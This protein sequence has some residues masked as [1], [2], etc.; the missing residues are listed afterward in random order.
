MNPT[1]IMDLEGTT[2]SSSERNLLADPLVSG[3]IFFARN[4]IDR[5]QISHLIAEIRNIRPNLLL[6]VDQEGGRVQR[7]KDGFTRLPALQKIGRYAEQHGREEAGVVAWH[8]GW[9]MAVELLEVG[10]DLSFAPVLD[11]DDGRS[12]VIGDR[13]FGAQAGTVI[14]LAVQYIDGMN[15]AGMGAVA[16]HFPGHGAVVEDSHKQLPIDPRS[17]GEIDSHDMLPFY[18]L[19]NRCIGVM[20]AHILCPAIDDHPIGFSLHWLKNVLRGQCYFQGTIFSD[21]LSMAATEQYG[22]YAERATAA[23]NAGCEQLLMCNNRQGVEQAIEAL[24]H[25]PTLSIA[26]TAALTG[27]HTRRQ[28]W[29]ANIRSRATQWCEELQSNQ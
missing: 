24:R 15:T 8:I 14:S 3:V 22:N 19:V 27:G 5:Q 6:T 23:L 11:L 2:L 13:S 16:K 18:A 21:D 1:I 29:D 7:F 12:Q 9:L 20:P 26:R 17:W 4:F 10:I 28:Q 25:H